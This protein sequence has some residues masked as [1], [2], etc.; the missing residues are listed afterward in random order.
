MLLAWAVRGTGDLQL[1]EAHALQF[2]ALVGI[3]SFRG[4]VG[5]DDAT[6]FAG[7]DQRRQ[8]QRI[9]SAPRPAVG[10]MADHRRAA[11]GGL[12][13]QCDDAPARLRAGQRAAAG[14]IELK[15]VEGDAGQ[16]AALAQTCLRAGVRSLDHAVRTDHQHRLLD[17]SSELWPQD[18]GSSRFGPAIVDAGGVGTQHQRMDAGP[19]AGCRQAAQVAAP[20]TRQA[21]QQASSRC[22]LDEQ[23]AARRQECRLG[24]KQ[25]GQRAA[26]QLRIGALEKMA[27]CA[28]DLEDGLV[29]GDDQAFF[30]EFEEG[31]IESG[32]RA[33]GE[34]GDQCFRGDIRRSP[35]REDVHASNRTRL[36]NEANVTTERLVT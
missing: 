11:A 27:G 14:R 7:T 32:L 15:R 23:R 5:V 4:T 31:Q 34:V 33:V 3:G 20:A 6:V 30:D 25:F 8:R 13:G 2:A 16:A 18:V 12:G 21:K 1:V 29:A 26:D 19:H 35:D 10:G 22:T 24:R 9:E 28:V 36:R 17:R